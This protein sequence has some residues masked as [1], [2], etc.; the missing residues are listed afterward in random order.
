MSTLTDPRLVKSASLLRELFEAR[1]RRK[2]TYTQAII[3]LAKTLSPSAQELK[4][5][6][7]LQ[8]GKELK[9]QVALHWAERLA[10]L[11]NKSELT[12]SA[13][14][15]Q[16]TPNETQVVQFAPETPTVQAVIYRALNLYES[17]GVDLERINLSMDLTAAKHSMPELDFDSLL[18]FKDADFLHDVSGI[19]RNLNRETGMLE[20]HFLPRCCRTRVAWAC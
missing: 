18:G 4:A 9:H 19:I 11:A 3:C 17:H 16:K 10:E 15:L 14:R 12:E 7:L 8:N 6:V 5:F 1:F 2:L 20:N 13:F